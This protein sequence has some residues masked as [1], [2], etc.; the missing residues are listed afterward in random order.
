VRLQCLEPAEANAFRLCLD[1]LR[2]GDSSEARPRFEVA[3]KNGTRNRDLADFKYLKES[4]RFE[5]RLPRLDSPLIPSRGATGSRWR[6]TIL[7]AGASRW[8]SSLD[9]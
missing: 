8:R 2:Y 3:A 4:E 6:S 9:V 1:E 5:L 7:S